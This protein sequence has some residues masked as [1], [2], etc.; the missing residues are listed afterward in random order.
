MEWQ[1]GPPS[2]RSALGKSPILPLNLQR[3]RINSKEETGC[4]D[5]NL[6][7]LAFEVP[8]LKV[9]DPTERPL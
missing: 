2:P 5:L 1:G 6:D 8:V 3:P 4:L 9:L 7:P